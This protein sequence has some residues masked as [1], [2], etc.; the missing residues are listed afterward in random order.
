MRQIRVPQFR[1][2]RAAVVMVI[3]GLAAT[4]AQADTAKNQVIKHWEKFKP[5]SSATLAATITAGNFSVQMEKK[6]A[7]IEVTSDKVTIETTVSTN[8]GGQQ[9]S[10]PPT[11]QTVGITSNQG[12]WTEVGH[13]KIEAAGKTFDCTV[14]EGKSMAP[15]RGGPPTEGN[16]KMWISDEVPGGIVQLKVNGAGHEIIY[17]LSAFE[18]K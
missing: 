11:R 9:R 2:T 17:K 7:L 3:L 8:M 12:D 6:D 14:V 5:G 18:V 16:A 15:S 4:V 10:N 13:E 1:L